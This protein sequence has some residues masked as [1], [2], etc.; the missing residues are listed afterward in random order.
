MEKKKKEANFITKKIEIKKKISEIA[1]QTKQ[2][3]I[4]I[5]EKLRN[6]LLSKRKDAQRK[7]Q[8]LADKMGDIKLE[9]SRNLLKASKKGC[10]DECDPERPETEILQYCKN[11]FNDMQ[12]LGECV[13]NEAFCPLC[14]ESEFGELHLEDRSE[15]YTKCNDYYINR[16]KFKT[17]KVALNVDINPTSTSKRIETEDV[18][19]N[20]E[21]FM[22]NNRRERNPPMGKKEI[23]KLEKI[24]VRRIDDT[25]E[26]EVV[27]EKEKKESSSLK[28]QLLKLIKQDLVDLES[29]N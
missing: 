3:I 26:K 24:G 5:R 28:K 27:K 8:I 18:G 7:R 13:R 1:K 9:I 12:K 21:G 23:L 14:C 22:N 29:E 10:A 4:E 25:I 17:N 2:Q 16:I 6:R 19:K 20:K 11:N 15:C